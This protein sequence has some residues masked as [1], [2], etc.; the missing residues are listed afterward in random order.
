MHSLS[1]SIKIIPPIKGT[2]VEFNTTHLQE[3]CCWWVVEMKTSIFVHLYDNGKVEKEQSVAMIEGI[4][5]GKVRVRLFCRHVQSAGQLNF[6]FFLE[7]AL[8]SVN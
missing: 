2:R 1:P 6:F 8:F 7:S 3:T 4:Y 5:T